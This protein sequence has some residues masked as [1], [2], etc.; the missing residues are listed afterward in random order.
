MRDLLEPLLPIIL[1]TLGVTATAVWVFLQSGA[2]PVIKFILVP[3]TI[4]GALF[5]P[6]LVHDMLGFS[7]KRDL[8]SQ[9]TVMAHKVVVVANRK[10]RIEVWGL[11]KAE[12]RLYNLPY[13]EKLEQAL[14]E[15]AE[16]RKGG[17]SAS[18][19]KGNK[20]GDH[21]NGTG[22]D[23]PED[24]YEVQLVQPNGITDKVDE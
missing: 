18:L 5:V 14:E 23:G 24:L 3:A 7:V 17:K 22:E 10:Q 13:S 6:L 9:V 1:V 16:A 4:V 12:S 21:R 8:P 15:A 20:Q 19:R 2:Q 11:T